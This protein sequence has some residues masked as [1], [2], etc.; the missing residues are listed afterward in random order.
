MNEKELINYML[1]HVQE[2]RK[3]MYEIGTTNDLLQ[4]K[5]VANEQFERNEKVLRCLL[6]KLKRG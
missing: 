2:S 4:I 3:S 5:K 1:Q 6:D